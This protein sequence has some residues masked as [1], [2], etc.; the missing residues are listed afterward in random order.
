MIS[1]GPLLV[2]VDPRIKVEE[3]KNGTTLIIEDIS[4]RDAGEYVCQVS[5]HYKY[6]RL[7][8]VL[9]KIS[10]LDEILTLT[11]NLEVLGK[12]TVSKINL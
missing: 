12:V 3:H 9:F 5:E 8:H 10:T 6:C 4:E 7:E 2:T 1:T 11:H